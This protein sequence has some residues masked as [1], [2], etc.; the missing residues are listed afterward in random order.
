[1]LKKSFYSN[2]MKKLSPYVK[3]HQYIGFD[4]ETIGDENKFYSGGLYWFHKGQERFNYFTDKEHMARFMLTR[5]FRN[6]YIV[7][8]NLNFDFTVVFYN[9]KYWNKFK[10]L[11]RQGNI[12]QASYDLGNNNGKIKFIDTANYAF[13][14]V[15]KLGEIIGTN[16]FTAPDFLGSKPVTYEDRLELYNY[17]RQDCKISHDFM[18]FF[19]DGINA[20]GGTVQL[21]LASTSLKMWRM[22][23]QPLNLIK[24]EYILKDASVKS[25]IFSGY[26]GGRTEVFKR[27]TFD[28]V[29]YYDVNSLYPSVM[30]MPFPLPQS[31]KHIP[32]REVSL[33]YIM[34]YEGVTECR[35]KVTNI[36]KPL[37]PFRHNEKLCFP[38]GTFIGTWNNCEL[39]KA[40]ELGYEI[41][42]L[43]QIIYTE[44]FYPFKSF[45]ENMFK[46]RRQYQELNNPYEF[47]VK[48][49]MNC[50]YGK[51]GS[52]YIENYQIIDLAT[53][54]GGYE[55]FIKLV[56]SK[57]YDFKDGKIIIK[58][59]KEFNGIYSFPILASYVT[60]Y[61]RLHMYKYLED[62]NIVYTDTDSVISTVPLNENSTLLGEMKR[63][64]IYYD[65]VFIKPKFYKLGISEDIKISSWSG[66][67]LMVSQF[68]INSVKIKG[69]SKP[70]S[71]DFIDFING[72][73]VTKPKFTRLKEAVRRGLTPN[74]I[75][76]ITKSLSLEDNKRIWEHTD[77]DKISNSKPIEVNI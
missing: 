59:I 58:N 5:K 35:V 36:D 45:V 17:N 56:G 25:F 30:R 29:Y 1:M 60:S 66:N 12:L 27:G 73:S 41:E 7:A 28:K 2:C 33:N 75:I 15:K 21:T 68:K 50:L 44:V 76:T 62:D 63:E 39:R 46:L 52:K 8:T 31:V 24:E 67:L 65:S 9:T 43:K 40:I 61:A 3:K 69:V 74:K 53:I 42:P 14:S 71:N 4:V 37:L 16:K 26:Y 64:G 19:Q 70:N 6:K 72:S 23:Y 32:N 55:G 13:M 18:N 34:D 38:T 49:L 57:D 47:V 77:L 48:I 10:I 20:L 54:E 11:M 22:S 51:F